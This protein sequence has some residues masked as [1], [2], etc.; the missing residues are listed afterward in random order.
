MTYEIM[1]S[2]GHLRSER[3]W[4]AM[5]YR[6]KEAGNHL[7]V[8]RQGNVMADTYVISDLT[9]RAIENQLATDGPVNITLLSLLKALKGAAPQS[10]MQK[11]EEAVDAKIT[12]SNKE[13]SN[14]LSRN[15][16]PAYT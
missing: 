15:P 16:D 12:E 11:L 6:H 2:V 7:K 9:I 3:G 4:E 5:L 14:T 8:V 1:G 10:L 13:P